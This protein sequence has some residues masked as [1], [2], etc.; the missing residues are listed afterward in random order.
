LLETELYNTRKGFEGQ[1][2]E[3]LLWLKE[4]KMRHK[5]VK[6]IFVGQFEQVKEEQELA[7][8]EVKHS[9]SKSEIQK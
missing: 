1:I 6:A 4:A 2:R 7:V 3:L 5:E 9:R 8:A